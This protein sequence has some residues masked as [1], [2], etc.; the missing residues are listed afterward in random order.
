MY[1]LFTIEDKEK[2]KTNEIFHKI[3][4]SFCHVIA[5]INNVDF[6]IIDLKTFCS[7][8]NEVVQI[9]TQFNSSLRLGLKGHFSLP[10]IIKIIEYSK[11]KK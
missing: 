6:N 11:K 2:V 3:S 9:L 7:D 5:N 1:D 10:S 4:E 8:L